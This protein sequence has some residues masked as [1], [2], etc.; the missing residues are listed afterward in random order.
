MS[1]AMTPGSSRTSA[2]SESA[3]TIAAA[4]GAADTAVVGT[5]FRE[6]RAFLGDVQLPGYDDEIA[7]L[8]GKYAPPKGALLLARDAGGMALGCI[9]LQPLQGGAGE[10][11]RLFVREAGRGAGLGRRLIEAMEAEARRIGYAELRLDTLPRLVPAVTL[12]RSLGFDFVGRYNDN[13]NP[14]VVFLAKRL[15]PWAIAPARG[16]RDVDDFRALCREYVD[17][18]RAIALLHL[19]DQEIAGLPEPYVPPK[20]EILLARDTAGAAIGCAALRPLPEAGAVELKRL[21]VI[22]AW[23]RRGLARALMARIFET[24]RTIGHREI[25]LDFIPSMAEGHALYRSL[26]FVE[27]DRYNQNPN[28][29]L[30]FMKKGL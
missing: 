20:G 25:K 24:A 21:Y 3:P 8:P 9:A 22:P 7:G 1:T 30:I 5:L 17:S 14:T 16:A 28:P 10:V 19:V 11:K 12:Y 27:I 4:R 13:P 6:Y 2:S 23:R 18:I 29:K 26:G 15:D